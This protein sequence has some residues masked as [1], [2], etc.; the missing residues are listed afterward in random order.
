MITDTQQRRLETRFASGADKSEGKK[1]SRSSFH[2]H[3]PSQS[4]LPHWYMAFE[5]FPRR[6]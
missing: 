6:A 5:I 4:V 2:P 3:L 1:Q